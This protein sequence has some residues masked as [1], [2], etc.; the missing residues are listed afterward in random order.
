MNVI[1]F[2]YFSIHSTSLPEVSAQRAKLSTRARLR[3][4]PVPKFT[5]YVGCP[6]AEGLGDQGN[7]LSDRLCPLPTECPWAM[8]PCHSLC[9]EEGRASSPSLAAIADSL[10]GPGHPLVSLWASISSSIKWGAGPHP[11]LSNYKLAFFL[12]FFL[13]FHSSTHPSIHSSTHPSIHPSIHPPV[14]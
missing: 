7:L 4:E 12:S 13:S 3:K 14:E 10:H 9:S 2:S 5:E 1:S 11:A 6:S 8:T